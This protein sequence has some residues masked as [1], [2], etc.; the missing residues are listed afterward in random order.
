MADELE[1]ASSRTGRR[2]WF[3]LGLAAGIGLLSLLA[4]PIERLVPIEAPILLVRATAMIQPA[5]LAVAAIFIGA[6]LAPRLG[7]RAPYLSPMLCWQSS[8]RK[9]QG[10]LRTPRRHC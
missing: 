10:P 8:T 5:I 1:A 7:L 6:T 2:P 4:M 3:G 9:P